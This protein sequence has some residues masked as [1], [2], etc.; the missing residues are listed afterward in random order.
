[1]SKTFTNV[2]TL[3][4]CKFSTYNL[5]MIALESQKFTYTIDPLDRLG[6]INDYAYWNERTYPQ[7]DIRT[8]KLQVLRRVDLY[9]CWMS[10]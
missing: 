3:N 6:I 2:K 10:P 8:T 4:P 5:I 1:M 9:S 7:T